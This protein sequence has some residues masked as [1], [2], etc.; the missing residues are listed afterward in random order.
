MDVL[1]SPRVLD[2]DDVAIGARLRQPCRPAAAGTPSRSR[3]SSSGVSAPYYAS[4]PCQYRSGL[5]LIAAAIIRLTSPHT[6]SVSPV[7]CGS[8]DDT[9]QS[10]Q[11]APHPDVFALVAP[12]RHGSRAETRSR[13]RLIGDRSRWHEAV[14]IRAAPSR[15]PSPS[16]RE[17]HI[18]RWC[19]GLLTPPNGA[20]QRQSQPTLPG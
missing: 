11:P 9:P 18:G 14:T 13:L 8:A 20:P 19:P 7:A 16:S 10:R 2:L 4:G 6:A 15:W 17:S 12:R 5:T 1:G 3:Q